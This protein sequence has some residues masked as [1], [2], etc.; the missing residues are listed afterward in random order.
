[1]TYPVTYGADPD[2]LTALWGNV[3]PAPNPHDV[4]DA[5]LALLLHNIAIGADVINSQL[6]KRSELQSSTQAWQDMQNWGPVPVA[7]EKDKISPP[8]KYYDAFWSMN[9]LNAHV[10][11]VGAYINGDFKGNLSQFFNVTSMSEGQICVSIGNDHLPKVYVESALDKVFEIFKDWQQQ[12]VPEDIAT[13]IRDN[14]LITKRADEINGLLA[15][16]KSLPYAT[17]NFPRPHA[18]PAAAQRL[19]A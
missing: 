16:G 13:I 18:A 11:G 6:F 5:N 1:M 19:T 3:M 8:F 4:A 7:R 17:R 9:Q 10:G 2:K 14:D 12:V 15:S